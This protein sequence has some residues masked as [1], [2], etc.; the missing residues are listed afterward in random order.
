V[1]SVDDTPPTLASGKIP[2]WE[3]FFRGGADAEVLTLSMPVRA[4]AAPGMPGTMPS[5]TCPAT[6]A[7]EVL[8]REA[9]QTRHSAPYTR[10]CQEFY[11]DRIACFPWPRLFI[12][13][14]AAVDKS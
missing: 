13:M 6:P 7:P 10:L 5:M 8:F 14:P 2:D 9:M 1:R 4:I 3:G 11:F 12:G